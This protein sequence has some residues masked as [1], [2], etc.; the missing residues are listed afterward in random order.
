[1]VITPGRSLSL[2]ACLLVAYDGMCA[3]GLRHWRGEF[4]IPASRASHHQENKH[5]KPNQN[6]SDIQ[7]QTFFSTNRS[8]RRHLNILVDPPFPRET[9]ALRRD[10]GVRACVRACRTLP[11]CAC[12]YRP[13]IAPSSVSS[14]PRNHSLDSLSTCAPPPPNCILFPHPSAITSTSCVLSRFLFI[15]GPGALARARARAH[16]VW[17]NV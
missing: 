13:A 17:G 14:L 15:P 7:S 1:M 8:T 3:D 10:L 11:T 9:R 2:L 16:R 4:P 12:S 5:N 6:N